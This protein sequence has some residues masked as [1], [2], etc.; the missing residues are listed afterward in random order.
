ML[1]LSSSLTFSSRT[2]PQ[3][4]LYSYAKRLINELKV[5]F[6]PHLIRTR[7]FSLHLSAMTRN[8]SFAVSGQIKK[9]HLSATSHSESAIVFSE[10]SHYFFLVILYIF[11]CFNWQSIALTPLHLCETK[12]YIILLKRYQYSANSARNVIRFNLRTSRAPEILR[13]SR[14][15][16]Q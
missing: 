12:G 10:W 13:D 16:N 7:V 1:A 5:I 9:G 2:Y 8:G 4:H 3:P 15:S 14:T 6:I 11:C